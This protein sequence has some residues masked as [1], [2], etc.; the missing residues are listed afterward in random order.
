MARMVIHSDLACG[1]SMG[2]IIEKRDRGAGEVKKDIQAEDAVTNVLINPCTAIP[3][4][5]P[6]YG[7]RFKRCFVFG[8]LGQFGADNHA[9]DTEDDAYSQ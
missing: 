8:L 6:I 3:V 1:L 4:P 5:F 9:D 7:S 2:S